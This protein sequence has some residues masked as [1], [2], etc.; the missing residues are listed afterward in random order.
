MRPPRHPRKTS[1]TP[2]AHQGPIG[3]VTPAAGGVPADSE[4]RKRAYE[5]F[6]SRA[7]DRPDPVADWLQAEHEL[8]AISNGKASEASK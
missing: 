4:V 5:I 1:I 7:A 2:A 3:E 8:R 6:L